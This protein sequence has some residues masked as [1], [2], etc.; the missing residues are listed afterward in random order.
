MRITKKIETLHKTTKQNSAYPFSCAIV[1]MCKLVSN[2]RVRPDGESFNT[3]AHRRGRQFVAQEAQE[4]K[5][6]EAKAQEAKAK[7]IVLAMQAW[8]G[9]DANGKAFI[10]QQM[11]ELLSLSKQDV[12]AT[13]L[14]AHISGFDTF[15]VSY[16]K[17]DVRHDMQLQRNRW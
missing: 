14:C 11:S 16:S 2:P 12:R 13:Q 5:A 6:Q 15:R 1:R 10:Q 8:L 17:Q 3:L 7:A 4:A 9:A